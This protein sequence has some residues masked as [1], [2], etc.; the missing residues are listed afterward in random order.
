MNAPIWILPMMKPGDAAETIASIDPFIR[1]SLIVVDNSE[2]GLDPSS[3]TKLLRYIRTGQNLGCSASWN[4][5]RDWALRLDASLVIV[6][7]AVV[8][9]DGGTMVDE[10][11]QRL[12]PGAAIRA[13][14]AWHLVT[15]GP[16]L[17]RTVGPF[18]VGF[19]PVYFEDTDYEYR[20]RLAGREMVVDPSLNETYSDK[21]HARTWRGGFVEV[22]YQRQANYYAAK[23][24]GFEREET[25]VFPFGID[26]G[27]D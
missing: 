4:V 19:W 21:G 11:A 7:E 16:E 17:L 10:T 18:D 12:Y 5:G 20:M 24:G 22:D 6:S 23:W 15:L 13:D 9:L 1:Q 8:F 25:F 26:P 27:I 2:G 14:Q 3:R